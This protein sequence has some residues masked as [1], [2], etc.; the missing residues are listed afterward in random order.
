[1]TP[2]IKSTI[3]IGGH[4]LPLRFTIGLFAEAERRTGI[5]FFPLGASEFWMQDEAGEAGSI[6]MMYG[7]LY[8][9][10]QGAT[11]Q[12]LGIDYDWFLENVGITE[13]NKVAVYVQA[14]LERFFHRLAKEIKAETSTS[15]TNEA[16]TTSE[17][18]GPSADT[19][20]A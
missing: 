3:K 6:R 16:A 14:E 10:T 7:L 11:A 12:R 19:T 2:Q 17:S 9:G 15:E 4:S 20:S 5:P 13:I 18:S 8:A 1:M